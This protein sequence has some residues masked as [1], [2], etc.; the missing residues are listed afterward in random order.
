MVFWSI[1]LPLHHVS[2]AVI[3]DPCLEDLGDLPHFSLKNGQQFIVLRAAGEWVRLHKLE[4]HYW[5]DQWS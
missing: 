2:E 1:T 4:L 5:E 3:A